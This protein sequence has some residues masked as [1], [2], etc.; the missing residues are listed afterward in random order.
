MRDREG[1][2]DTERNRPAAR[3]N[4]GQRGPERLRARLENML[5]HP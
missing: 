1:H 5:P 4:E 3:G 2:A